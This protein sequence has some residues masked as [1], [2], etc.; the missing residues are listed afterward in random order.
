MTPWK[1][2]SSAAAAAQPA[3]TPY[4]ISD[5]AKAIIEQV[6]N[7]KCKHNII[8]F[9][10]DKDTCVISLKATQ[11]F[12][13]CSRADRVERVLKLAKKEGPCLFLFRVDL[14]SNSPEWALLAWAPSDTVLDAER[15][16]Y[17]TALS[18]LS[19]TIGIVRRFHEFYVTQEGEMPSF[20]WT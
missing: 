3:K 4:M 15:M 16:F 9:V 13:P 8:Q 17:F 6:K 18:W 5:E 7:G 1:T 20:H 14:K 12:D 11:P 19:G 10:V 2:T